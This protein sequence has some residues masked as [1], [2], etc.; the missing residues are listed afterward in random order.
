MSIDGL[1]KACHKCG[2]EQEKQYM[3]EKRTPSNKIVYLCSLKCIQTYNLV[4][5]S[6]KEVASGSS[7]KVEKGSISR[8]RMDKNG[9]TD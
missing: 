7:K 2:Y 4:F 9:S 6:I 8:L 5:S 3:F 1:Q